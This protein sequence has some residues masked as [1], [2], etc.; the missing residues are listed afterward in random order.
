M[1]YR[2]IGTSGLRVTPVCLGTMTFGSMTDKAEA[3]RIMDTAYERGINFFDTAELYPVPPTAEQA[4]ITETMVGEWLADKPRG[5][6]NTNTAT[7][8][9]P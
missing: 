3:F 6:P 9:T 8:A 5:W 1:E 7:P 2:Y 4:G